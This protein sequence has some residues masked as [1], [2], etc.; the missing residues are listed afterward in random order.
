MRGYVALGAAVSSL[1]SS[2]VTSSLLSSS[3][4]ASSAG[5]LF[6]SRRAQAERPATFSEITEAVTVLGI[7]G[8]PTMSEKDLKTK[9]RALVKKHHP[10]AG[11]SEAMMSKVT[12]A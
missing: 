7:E 4:S 8:L 5:T 3:P 6:F 10:D 2:V 1:R 11:G 9:Y 12:V